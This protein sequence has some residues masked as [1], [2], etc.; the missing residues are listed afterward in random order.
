MKLHSELPFVTFDLETTGLDTACDRIIQIGI[1]RITL[2]NTAPLRGFEPEHVLYK[3]PVNPQRPIPARVTEITGITDAMV[4]TAPTFAAIAEE[5]RKLIGDNCYIVGFNHLNFDIPVLWEEFHRCGIAW[6]VKLPLC[7]D[8]GNLFRKVEPRTLA[9]LVKKLFGEE[10]A[11][12]HDASADATA[13]F[14]CLGAMAEKYPELTNLG[15][16]ELA[17]FSKMDDLDGQPVER[18]DLAGLLVRD[19]QG[20]VRYTHKKVRG[21]ALADDPGYAEW[22]LRGGFSENTKQAIIRELESL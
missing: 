4:A 16:S 22:M 15:A 3:S 7:I 19:A 6:D 5:V 11:E 1:Q 21:V 2:D 9:A 17:A 12:A 10:L 20:V 13:T 18:V 8:V 14:R